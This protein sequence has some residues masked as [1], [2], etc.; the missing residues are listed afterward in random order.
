MDTI[1]AL[2]DIR[3]HHTDLSLLNLARKKTEMFID[4][5]YETLKSEI[6]KQCTYRKIARSDYHATAKIQSPWKK[7]LRRELCKKLGYLP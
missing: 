4:I 5:L 3:L 6:D 1:C 2:A 7:Q